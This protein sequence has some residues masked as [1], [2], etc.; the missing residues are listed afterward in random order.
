VSSW[1]ILFY[2]HAFT[3]GYL[4]IY[5]PASLIINGGFDGSGTHGS[6]GVGNYF[7]SETLTGHVNVNLPSN[8]SNELN[9]S[10]LNRI[11]ASLKQMTRVAR[12]KRYLMRVI[13]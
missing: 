12:V 6:L 3:N 2:F 7:T 1:A 8:Y 9:S 5:P 13:S 10:L 11:R 4:T